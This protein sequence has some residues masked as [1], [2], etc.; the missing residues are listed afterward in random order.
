MIGI[1]PYISLQL[2]AISNSFSILLQYPEIVMPDQQSAPLVPA[3]TPRFYV[4][5]M[6]AAFTILFGTRHLDAAEHHEGMVAA[7]AFESLVKLLAFLAVGVFVTFGIYD[8]FGDIF[9]RARAAAELRALLTPLDGVAGGYANWVVA[10]ALSMLAIMFLPRQFQV[11]VVENVDEQHLSKAIWLF[12]LYLLRDQHLRAADRVRRAAAL[13]RT[14]PSTP[15]PSCSRCRW[16]RSSE[17]LALLAFIGGLSAATGMVIV[18]TIALSTMV[19][20]DLVMPV[21]LRLRWLR[22]DERRDLTGAAARHPA[23]RHRA[24]PAAR[25]SLLPARRAKPT[26]WSR[27]ASSRSPRSRSSRRRS[28]AASTGKAARGAGALAGLAGGLRW[29]GSTR[30]CCRRSPARAGCR[31]ASSSDGPFGID[32]LKPLAAVR[33]RRARP[34]HA[35]PVLEH[36]R[37]RRLPTSA[38]RSSAAQS[39]AEHSQATLFVDVFKQ[40]AA[41]GARFWRGTRLGRRLCRRCSAASSAPS[42][43]RSAFA[44]TRARA[45]PGGSAT[46]RRRP[47]PTSCTTSESLLAGAIGSAS[48]RVMVASVVEE[49]PLGI[50]E[51]MRHPR[52]GLAGRSPTAASSSRNRA[53]SRRRRASCARPTE[54]LQELDRLKDDFI[55]TV[56][57][58]L[59]TPLTSIRAFSEI[60]RDNPALDDAQRAKF[61]GIIIKETERLTRLINQVLDLAKIESGNAEWQ[62]GEIDMREVIDDALAAVSQLFKERSVE[63]TVRTPGAVPPV[64]ADRDR[65][66][67]VMLNLLSNAATFCERA[68][69]A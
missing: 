27:S 63:L 59:R 34:D 56:T 66:M 33:A 24:D 64:V 23:R 40:P 50:D 53:S 42:A 45:R 17:L 6:L 10:D 1:L 55:S 3:R 51:V 52:R 46:T 60:L 9:A 30:C 47:T 68:D 49:E 62:P 20:N 7:I 4:A 21:L 44:R 43:R 14:A 12:P 31:S 69:G 35:L 57:H 18:E 39:A 58:E 2:K 29:S 67:Q 16:P 13:S 15:I 36:A 38:C 65:L 37:Q 25:L 48:A 19:C 22:L 8:G 28:S 32:L 61:L 54:R 11:A 41:G 5:L 26:R